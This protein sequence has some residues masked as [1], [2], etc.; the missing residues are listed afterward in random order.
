[1]KID[2]VLKKEEAAAFRLRALYKK[3]GYL[4]FKMSKFEEYDLYVRNKDFLISDRIITFTDTDGT[5]LALKPDVTLS[6]IKSSSALSDSMEKFYYDENVYRVSGSTQCFKEIK[7][8]G[9]ECIGNIDLFSQCE[10]IALAIRSL[11]SLGGSYLLNLSHTGIVD[12]LLTEGVSERSARKRILEC[13]SSKNAHGIREVFAETGGNNAVCEALCTL[14]SMYG[15]PAEVLPKLEPLCLIGRAAEALA[16]LKAVSDVL[17]KQGLAE[18]LRVDFSIASDRN[19]YS[20]LVFRGFL[21]G[22]PSSILSGGRYDPLMQKMGKRC[23]AIGF[24]V[25]LDLL[26]LFSD[27]SEGY[28]VDVLLLYPEGT[29]AAEILSAQAALSAEGTVFAASQKPP[30][31]RYK[32]LIALEEGRMVTREDLR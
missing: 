32:R 17:E 28:G 22:I 3:S 19:Y 7:Q 23:G 5:L 27:D 12:A 8:S 4:P 30:K 13:L 25:Y 18:F 15:T 31:I 24:A 14:T 16:E 21:D 20:G 6:I 1:M 26:E 11:E 2:Q 29:D 10:V 9:L